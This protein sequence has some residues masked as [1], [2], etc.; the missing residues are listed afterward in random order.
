MPLT[1][2]AVPDE[3]P[4]F[5]VAA[6]VLWDAAGRVLCVRKRGTETFMLPGGKIEP[7]ESSDVTA[8]REIAEELGLVLDRAELR[9]VGCFVTDAANE[10]GHWVRADVYAYPHAVAGERVAAEI[11]AAR[12]VDPQHPDPHLAP[13]SLLVFPALQGWTPARG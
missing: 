7:G 3:G 12:W 6:V 2:P 9:L 10:P 8:V 4:G 1:Q 5:V 11:D 13:L